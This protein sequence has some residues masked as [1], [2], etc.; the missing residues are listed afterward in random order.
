[1]KTYL[2][3]VVDVLHPVLNAT[4][5]VVERQDSAMKVKLPGNLREPENNNSG[6]QVEQKSLK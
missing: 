2:D 6:S 3:P 4:L 1:M 5:G